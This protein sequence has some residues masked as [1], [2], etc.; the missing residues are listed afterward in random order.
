MATA[1]LSSD[2]LTREEA[3][4]YLGVKVGTLANWTTTG[5]YSLPMVKIGRLAKYRRRDLDSF[6]E[7]RTV[8]ADVATL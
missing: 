3:A 8:G 5:R 4:S 7:R 1:T 6:I 2:L